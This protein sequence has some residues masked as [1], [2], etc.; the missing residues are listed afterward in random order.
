MHVYGIEESKP[1]LTELKSFRYPAA[2]NA[3]PSPRQL[4]QQQQQQQQQQAQVAPGSGDT[5]TANGGTYE[6]EAVSTTEPAAGAGDVAIHVRV[7]PAMRLVAMITPKRG[8][9]SGAK[10]GFFAGDE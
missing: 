6:S 4:Q 8:A 7:S 3:D 10:E 1:T 2:Y 5:G 9:A